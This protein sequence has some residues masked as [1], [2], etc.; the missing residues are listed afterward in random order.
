MG[1][2]FRPISTPLTVAASAAIATS[3]GQSWSCL[4]RELGEYEIACRDWTALSKLFWEP[5]RR[6]QD[7]N[8]LFYHFSWLF[9]ARQG[10]LAA[11]V[12]RKMFYPLAYL[13]VL[14]T[15]WVRWFLICTFVSGQCSSVFDGWKFIAHRL[16]KA[17]VYTICTSY[18]P[19]YCCVQKD[20]QNFFLRLAFCDGEAAPMAT[21]APKIR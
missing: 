16:G 9:Q 4:S 21:A 17:G 3:G 6:F 2:S 18:L 10:N 7:E 14:V 20:C 11:G 19:N 1:S 13:P 8:H 15:V 12:L 5:W